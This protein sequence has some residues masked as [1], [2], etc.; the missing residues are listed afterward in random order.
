MK[1]ELEKNWNDIINIETCKQFNNFDDMKEIV[2]NQGKENEHHRTKIFELFNRTVL[3]QHKERRKKYFEKYKLKRPTD[4]IIFTDSFSYSSTSFFIKGLQETG[5]AIL[6]GYKGNPKSDEFFEASHSP[7][8]V[9]NFNGSEIYNSLLEEGFEIIGTTY[10]ESYNYSYQEK[11][12][13]PREYLMHEVDERINIY[14][15][16]DDTILE[17]FI[18]EAKK[19]FEKYNVKKECN[20]KNQKLLYDS[21]NKIDCYFFEEDEHAHG[22]YLCNETGQWSNICMPYYCDIGYYFDTYQNKCIKDQCTESEENKDEDDEFPVLVVILIVL[23]VIIVI[24]AIIIVIKLKISR[25]VKPDNL[26]S[27]VDSNSN[28]NN[29]LID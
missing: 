4:I 9:S 21:N 8:A 7:S 2:D 14:Q 13:I 5:S 25:K 20:P 27:I 23:F 22:G 24:T 3:K 17:Q 1:E 18:I 16:Y 12:P 6:V 15:N 29:N 19:I 26:G 11:N 28:I 10:F